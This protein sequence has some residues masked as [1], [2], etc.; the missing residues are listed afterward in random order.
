[1]LCVNG[2]KVE[3]DSASADVHS[4]DMVLLQTNATS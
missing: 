2:H 4:I 3:L 1:M